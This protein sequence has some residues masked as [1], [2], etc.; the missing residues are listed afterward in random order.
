MDVVEMELQ[1][2]L[3]RISTIDNITNSSLSKADINKYVL[4]ELQSMEISIYNA[5]DLINNT[6]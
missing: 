3:E 5:L 6:K 2:V 1:R 4:Q